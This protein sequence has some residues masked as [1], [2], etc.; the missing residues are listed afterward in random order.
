MP[1]L[2]NIA[3]VVAASVT[4]T[5]HTVA[6]EH[7]SCRT[8]APA[9]CTP[10][11]DEEHAVSMLSAGPCSAYT[12]A[13][14]PHA[15]LSAPPVAVYVLTASAMRAYSLPEMPTATP[16]S[17]P[18][19]LACEPC[20]TSRTPRA[21]SSS[22][23]CCGSMS[24]ASTSGTPKPS[25]SKRATAPNTAPKRARTSSL[26][27]TA[28]APACCTSHRSTGT[29]AIASGAHQLASPPAHPLLGSLA[30]LALTPKT[31]A[32]VAS[33]AEES[34]CRGTPSSAGLCPGCVGA[35]SPSTNATTASS[36]G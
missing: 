25:R 19:Q 15:T 27:T 23:R 20:A 1:A 29:G 8:A 2:L 22:T 16:C 12:Y 24:T 13:S 36:V 5:P 31:E 33:A 7:S 3:V 21:D 35:T 14:L 17:G 11:S 4:F 9:T 6:P 34:S 10:T 28:S 26:P 32:P 30:P 18:P